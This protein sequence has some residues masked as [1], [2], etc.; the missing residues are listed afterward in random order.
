VQKKIGLAFGFKPFTRINYSIQNISRTSID[1]M[2]NLY[3]GSGGLS[4]IFIGLG[5]KWKHI[6]LGFNTGYEWGKKN[7]KYQSGFLK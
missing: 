5:K 6:S 2:E 1:S 3:E 4:Q 7:I